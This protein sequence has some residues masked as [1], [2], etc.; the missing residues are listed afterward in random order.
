MTHPTHPTAKDLVAYINASPT[1]DHCV[2]ESARRLDEAGFQALDEGEGWSLEAGGGYYVVRGGSITAF[3]VGTGAPHEVGFRL[4]G[5]H[6]DSPNLRVKPIANVTASGWL[7]LG[8][9]TYGGLLD[10]TWLD[11][12]LGLAGSVRLREPGGRVT[13]RLVRVDR[14]ILRI[15]SLAIHLN[16]E[17][18]DGGL[19]LNAQ[20]HLPPLMALAPSGADGKAGIGALERL[21]GDE[22]GVDPKTI[23]SWDLSLMDVVPA[24][25]G[26]LHHELVFAPRLDNQAMCHAT[27]MA[28]LRSR[29][30]EATQVV[31]LYDH[32]EVGSGSTAGAEGNV[33]EVIL[34][35]VAEIEGPAAKP[36]GLTRAAAR[37]TQVSADMAH[38]VHPNYAD[39]HEPMHLPRVN[40]GPV[41]KMNA[42]QRYATNA[43]TAALFEA[44]CQDAE[45]PVQKFVT[46][47]DL[48]CGSTIGPIA[49]ARLGIQTVDVG[50]AMLSMHS[51]RE[52]TGAED[53]E[54][55]VT[56]LERFLQS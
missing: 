16:R 42:Q 31:A 7:Q 32:E 34:R 21:L 44:L 54:R 46:R 19:K 48:A 47:T 25:I 50:N 55:M 18:R 15:P 35:R 27:L 49:A 14:P 53:P 39:K 12:D 43:D 22:L 9:E 4:T 20:K 56:V 2:A 13:R 33:V 24:T 38:G 30:S 5:A 29:A 40:G 36:G 51:I 1:P 6:T 8:V 3:R 45:V 26:G 41:I 17:I 52:T 23:L 10:Y 37:S 28:L 11:R